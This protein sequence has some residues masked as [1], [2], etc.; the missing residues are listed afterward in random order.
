VRPFHRSITIGDQTHMSF[1]AVLGLDVLQHGLS[2]QR[3]W[4]SN[5]S[6]KASD[7]LCV[8]AGTTHKGR[9]RI[10]FSDAVHNQK[11]TLCL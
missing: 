3:A 5:A 4:I 11:S 8:C 6:V 2:R 1:T 10:V 7:S 9:T